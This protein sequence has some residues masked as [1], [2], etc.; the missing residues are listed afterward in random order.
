MTESPTG[1]SLAHTETIDELVSRLATDLE[2]LSAVEA[3]ARLVRYGPNELPQPPSPSWWKI[4]LRQFQSPLI[5]ILL[6]AAVVS[7]LLEEV[8]DATFI[9]AVLLLNAAIGTFQEWRAERSTQAL[10]RLLR[11]QATVL[12]DGEAIEI[13]ADQIVPGDVL[14]LESGGKVPADVRLAWVHGLEV[15]ESLLTGESLPVQKEAHWSGPPATPLADRLNMAS[16]GS[17]VVRGRAK[18]IVVATGSDTNVG[19]LAIDVLTTAGGKPPLLL[20]MERFT[21]VVA[22]AVLVSAAMVAVLGAAIHEYPWAEMFLF[23]VA[24]AV[25][26]IPEGLPVAMTI[27][28]SVATRRMAQRGVIVRRLAAV[29]GL[30]SC[31]LVAS[32]KTGTLTCNELTVR[33]IV[34]A[35]GAGFEVTGQGFVPEGE[36]LPRDGIA[37][38]AATDALQR[39]ARTAVLCNE[40]DLHRHDG[41]WTWRGDAVDVALLAMAHKLGHARETTLDAWPQENEIPFEPERRFAATYHRQA[42]GDGPLRV[43]VKGAPERVME[44]CRSANETSDE[45]ADDRI[46]RR[47]EALYHEGYRVL[48]L[49]DGVLDQPLSREVSPADPAG[50]RLIGLV[51]MIDPLREGVAEA[52]GK[53][54]RAGV[55]VAMVTGDHPVTA[56]AIARELELACDETE[57]MTGEQLAAQA[58]QTLADVFDRVRVFARVTPHQKLQL[59]EAARAAGHFV[60]VTGDGVNDAPALRAANI[61]VAMGRSGTD[62]AREAAELVISDDNF[63]TLVTGIEQGRIAYDNVRK[64]IYLLIS[65]GAAEVVVMALA[66]AAGLPLPLLAVQLLWLNLVTNGIQ[67]VALAFE[68]GE[69]GVLQ[70]PPRSPRERVFNRL[71]V[72]RTLVAAAV[73]GVVG[74]CAYWWML[75]RGWDEAAARNALLLLMVLFETVHIGNC[76]SETQSALTHSPLKSPILLVAAALALLLHLVALHTS[77]GQMVLGMQPVEPVLLLN[78][79][80]LALTVFVAMELHKWSWKLRQP[81]RRIRSG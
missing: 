68:P 2:G 62:V 64:V 58:S 27:A 51:A 1:T 31:T 16:A 70:R 34:L 75:Q 54:R 15:D 63:A 41:A 74:S 23:A 11:M 19:Q 20:R 48:A 26:A 7:L 47:V 37:I 13:D 49:A 43:F 40:A 25:S 21:R 42:D 67:D 52:I 45:G 6:V 76:R 56:L 55:A 12:R 60:A 9:A 53:C 77:F 57:V 36:V 3:A 5:Y 39:L 46:L 10:R 18:G 24:L 78:L 61:G 59:V 8:V 28:L 29:E 80:L 69:A 38:Q 65:T 81:H 50:L 22:V 35:D 73:M 32:D 79:W 71:M 33:R 17:T 66:I 72:E 44:M 30:G 4:A 14:W